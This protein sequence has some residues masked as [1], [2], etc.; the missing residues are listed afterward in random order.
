MNTNF[1]RLGAMDREAHASLLAQLETAPWNW[2]NIRRLFPTS[3]HYDVV[4]VVC[5]FYP[6]TSALSF[7]TV[8]NSMEC[9]DYFPMESIKGLREFITSLQQTLGEGEVGRVMFTY[10]PSGCVID[11]HADEGG[12]AAAHNRYH[13][14]MAAGEGSVFECDGEE[15]EMK[16][17][18]VWTFNHKLIHSVQN[19]SVEPRIHLVVDF[20]NE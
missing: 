6:V 19:N 2:L 13:I 18:E 3:A 8:M 12:Y 17:G 14:V 9:V 11:K 16:T 15:V 1:T 20:K 10:L 4:D 5:R 7:D